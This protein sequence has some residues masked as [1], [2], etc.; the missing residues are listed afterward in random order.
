MAAHRPK[1]DAGEMPG[2]LAETL[3]TD[4]QHQTQR[5]HDKAEDLAWGQLFMEQNGTGH[6]NQNGCK[7][8]AEGSD[9]NG[10]VL[11]GLEQQQPVCAYRHTGQKQQRQFSAD[12]CEG[13]GRAAEEQ[14][15]GNDQNGQQAPVEHHLAGTERDV[16]GKEPDGSENSHGKGHGSSCVQQKRPPCIRKRLFTIPY[17]IEENSPCVNPGLRLNLFV[18][19][20]TTYNSG[21]FTNP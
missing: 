3:G 7:V 5:R 12:L 4:D 9:G 15:E 8:I 2:I 13:D 16:L 21:N 6:G 14:I 17:K 20:L 19:G 18:F 1:G 11:I 10:G